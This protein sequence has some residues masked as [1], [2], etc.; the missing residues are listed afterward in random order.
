MYICSIRVRSN[1]TTG[2]IFSTKYK[3]AEQTGFNHLQ[4]YSSYHFLGH[5]A[6]IEMFG[7]W[8]TKIEAIKNVKG[9]NY[10]VNLHSLSIIM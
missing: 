1:C 2:Q 7:H 6:Y 5:E 10:C 3:E 8:R 9:A 4:T